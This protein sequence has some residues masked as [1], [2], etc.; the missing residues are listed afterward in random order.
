ME[1]YEAYQP[2]AKKGFYLDPR[3]KIL[4]MAFVTTLMFFVYENLAMDVWVR[5]SEHLPK[6]SV[7]ARGRVQEAALYHRNGT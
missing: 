2:P 4:F 5:F 7:P 3:T 6:Q 1:R